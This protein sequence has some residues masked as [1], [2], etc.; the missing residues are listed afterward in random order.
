M[1]GVE[2]KQPTP[3]TGKHIV[4]SQGIRYNLK[5]GLTLTMMV[6]LIHNYTHDLN[7]MPETV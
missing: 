2:G 3:L 1:N 5:F 4:E 6:G 7:H